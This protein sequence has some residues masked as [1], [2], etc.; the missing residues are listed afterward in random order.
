MDVLYILLPLVLFLVIGAVIA[1]IWSLKDGQMDDLD[2]PAVRVLF[3]EDSER[4]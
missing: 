3:D 4:K 2:T 1:F